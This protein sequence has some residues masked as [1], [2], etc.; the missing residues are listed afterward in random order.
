[1]K[2]LFIL[3]NLILSFTNASEH[4]F[5]FGMPG[6]EKQAVSETRENNA[7]YQKLISKDP[8]AGQTFAE[9]LYPPLVQKIH[10]NTNIPINKIHEMFKEQYPD[11]TLTDIIIDLSKSGFNR[12]YSPEMILSKFKEKLKEKLDITVTS[13]TLEGVRDKLKEFTP[14]PG[15]ENSEIALFIERHKRYAAQDRFGTYESSEQHISY[16]QPTPNNAYFFIRPTN[17]NHTFSTGFTPDNFCDVTLSTPHSNDSGNF[18]DEASRE[19]EVKNSKFVDDIKQKTLLELKNKFNGQPV[20]ISASDRIPFRM[21]ARF[22]SHIKSAENANWDF[23][24]L[25]EQNRT[26]SRF[27]S[28]TV[29]GNFNARDFCR[30]G[31]DCGSVVIEEEAVHK[32][33]HDY[34]KDQQNLTIVD[35]GSSIGLNSIRYTLSNNHVILC[36]QSLDALIEAGNYMLQDHPDKAGNLYLTTKSADQLTLPENSVDVVFMGYLIKYFPG[37]NIDQMLKNIFN[38]LKPGGKLFLAEITPDNQFYEKHREGPPSPNEINSHY[39]NRDYRPYTLL[40]EEK[41]PHWL[42][43]MGAVHGSQ[44]GEPKF[45]YNLTKVTEADVINGLKRAGFRVEKNLQ[46]QKPDGQYNY[47][48]MPAIQIIAIKP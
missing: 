4:P 31:Q 43:E 28:Q 35:L 25:A 11:K 19:F 10:E 17:Y 24:S 39:M 45:Q 13:D 46:T 27:W 12:C 21:F 33:Y 7:C 34:L 47:N 36:E 32:A 9:T 5:I 16:E 6:A 37:K 22:P 42:G 15:K 8:A 38:Y 3:L 44:Y 20:A 2:S 1:M 29:A 41:S 40:F 14:T 26:R 30:N 23:S 18:I 48:H